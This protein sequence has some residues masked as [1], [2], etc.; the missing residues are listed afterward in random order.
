LQLFAK[1]EAVGPDE[2]FS[3]CTPDGVIRRGAD[4]LGFAFHANIQR[5]GRFMMKRA[6]DDLEAGTRVRNQGGER[7][8]RN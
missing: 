2:G 5:L 1:G 3:V 4:W 7:P 6:G 8:G